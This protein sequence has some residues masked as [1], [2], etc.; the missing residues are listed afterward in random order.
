MTELDTY[1]PEQY[2]NGFNVDGVQYM[3]KYDELCEQLKNHPNLIFLR[4]VDETEGLP[5]FVSCFYTFVYNRH[6]V[7]TQKEF[8]EYYMR[9]HK[10]E[11]NGR[12]VMARAYR[13][14]PSLIRDTHFACMM[15]KLNQERKF[16]DEVK[17]NT[18]LDM[19]N[20]ADLMLTKGTKHVALCL[21][22]K[23]NKSDNNRGKKQ[24]KRFSNVKYIECPIDIDYDNPGFTLY[25][26]DYANRVIEKVK[27]LF[28]AA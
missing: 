14:Y 1:N 12:D 17:Y 19:S 3:P 8:Y 27:E 28:N 25:T 22:A 11:L 5:P 23:G 7:P 4:G 6:R 2:P 18:T 24:V 10:D 15:F 20:D 9:K 13:A 21:F 16:A 26:E